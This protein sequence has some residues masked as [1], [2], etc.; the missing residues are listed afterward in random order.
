MSV[1]DNELHI[2]Y[3]NVSKKQTKMEDNSSQNC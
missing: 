3:D 1:Y 2:Y